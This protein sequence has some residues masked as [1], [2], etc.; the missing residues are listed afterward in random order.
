VTLPDGAGP[1][2]ATTTML[3]SFRFRSSRPQ[4]TVQE[5]APEPIKNVFEDPNAPPEEK[6]VAPVG[7]ENEVQMNPSTKDVPLEQATQV[8][9][10]RVPVGLDAGAPEVTDAAEDAGGWHGGAEDNAKRERETLEQ[11][12]QETDGRPAQEPLVENVKVEKMEV[13]DEAR[14]LAQAAMDADADVLA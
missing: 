3:V 5:E 8:E 10:L 2:S 11:Q 12:Q 6:T 7:P 1:D 4:L 13:D 14:R 9:D